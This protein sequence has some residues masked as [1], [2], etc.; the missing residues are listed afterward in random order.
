MLLVSGCD[1]DDGSSDI[2]TEVDMSASVESG[3]G[4]R[5]GS[6]SVALTTTTTVPVNGDDSRSTQT[7]LMVRN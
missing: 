7:G 2:A 5:S 3:S 6:A 4:G 1:E